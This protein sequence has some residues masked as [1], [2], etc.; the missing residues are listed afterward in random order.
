MTG[1]P[2]F[3]YYCEQYLSVVTF[4]PGTSLQLTV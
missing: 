3:D 4:E 2:D 1:M